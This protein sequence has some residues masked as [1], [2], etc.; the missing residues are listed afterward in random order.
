MKRSVD[1]AQ[2]TLPEIIKDCNQWAPGQ[3]WQKA[4]VDSAENVW[5]ATDAQGLPGL[6]ISQSHGT[7]QLSIGTADWNNY[8]ATTT[9]QF[10]MGRAAGLAVATCG[11]RRQL[12]VLLHADRSVTLERLEFASTTLLAKGTYI[13]AADQQETLS[14]AWSG[15]TL[16]VLVN[17][18]EPFATQK[19][20]HPPTGGGM[21]LIVVEGNATFRPSIAPL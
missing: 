1:P 12:R 5:K 2:D 20:E 10:K 3:M 7:G 17:E 9:L 18:R 8:R 19:I 4:Y 11:L 21:A 15:D 14:M 6:K 13:P 16:R